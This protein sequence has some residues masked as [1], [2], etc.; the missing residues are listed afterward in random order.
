MYKNP[1]LRSV[2]EA[3]PGDYHPVLMASPNSAA[4]T[5][6]T[7]SPGFTTPLP[8]VDEEDSQYVVV[9]PPRDHIRPNPIDRSS[10]VPSYYS[11]SEL[12]AQSPLPPVV[13]SHSPRQDAS[14]LLSP[15]HPL[16]SRTPTSPLSPGSQ[17]LN[18]PSS[19][20]YGLNGTPTSPGFLSS[21]QTA[22]AP[23]PSSYEMRVRSPGGSINSH[24]ASESTFVTAHEATADDHSGAQTL[25]VPPGLSGQGQRHE[26]PE[27]GTS[28]A[29]GR[30]L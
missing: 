19:P 22:Y 26:R 30:A 15:R 1:H 20:I 27:S 2:S 3:E 12:P 13:Y 8:D 18:V 7:R 21:S 4:N 14:A 10:L 5:P 16:E 23:P 28:W 24:A 9:D 11:A 29:G 17:A 6:P 25:F